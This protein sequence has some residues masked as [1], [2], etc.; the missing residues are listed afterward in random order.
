MPQPI[1][2]ITEPGLWERAL[3]L[4]AYT[5]STRG[6]AL[7]DVGYIHCSYRHQVEAVANF[8]YGDWDV[9]LLLLQIDPDDVPSEIRIENLEGGTE[10]F[11]HI[12]GQLPTRAVKAV[13]L[14][15][16]ESGL[17]RLPRALVRPAPR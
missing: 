8:I 1:F 6:A 3:A 4:G 2:H 10:G 16:R 15:I 12:Y 11:P 13:H 17:W 5:C 9:D 7:R 14:L